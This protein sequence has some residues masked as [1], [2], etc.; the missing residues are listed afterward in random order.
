[1]G[2]LTSHLSP[3]GGVFYLFYKSS[4]LMPHLSPGGGGGG[5][6]VCVCVYMYMGGGV[7]LTSA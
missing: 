6:G 7:T 2:V 3:I 4:V 1:M 5:G